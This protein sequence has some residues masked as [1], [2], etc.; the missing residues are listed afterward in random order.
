M[1]EQQRHCMQTFVFAYLVKELFDFVGRVHGLHFH[2]LRLAHELRR[3]L[4]YAFGVS[5]RKQQGLALRRA[6]F[7]ELRN[8]VEKTHVQHAIG[9]I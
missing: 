3:Q 5:S 8:V 1:V 4:A 2:G 9:F 6:L 7:D